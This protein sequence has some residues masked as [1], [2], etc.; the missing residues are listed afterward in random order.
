MPRPVNERQSLEQE[1][2]ELPGQL[3]ANQR[4]L[5]VTPVGTKMRREDAMLRGALA[6]L[7]SSLPAG[8]QRRETLGATLLSICNCF[9]TSSGPIVASP[10]M[11]PP[12]R[13]R[14]ATKPSAT[15]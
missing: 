8:R 14:L 2:A 9:P 4:E 1:R 6:Q 13:A 5:A 10:V 15:G 7:A 11:F 3:T 12:G